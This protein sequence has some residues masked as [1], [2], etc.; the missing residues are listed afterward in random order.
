MKL[1]QTTEDWFYLLAVLV[2]V[3]AAIFLFVMSVKS[4]SGASGFFGISKSSQM[5]VVNS[6]TPWG[7]TP[8]IFKLIFSNYGGEWC[9]SNDSK[10]TISIR[11]VGNSD[12]KLWFNGMEWISKAEEV[13]DK[14]IV[15]GPKDSA[16]GKFKMTFEMYSSDSMTMKINDNL[17]GILYRC[18]PF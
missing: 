16:E 15:N 4:G 11:P 6:E 14:L 18:I 5:E 13:G 9:D 1:P 8:E 12:L 10:Y 17:Y 7:S 3:I 2:L